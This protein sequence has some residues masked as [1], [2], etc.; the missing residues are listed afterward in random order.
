MRAALSAIAW[1]ALAVA[2]VALGADLYWCWS[3]GAWTFQPLGF[4]LNLTAADWLA[5][6]RDW[7]ASGSDVGVRLLNTLLALPVWVPAFAIGAPLGFATRE[8]A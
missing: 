8:R 5:Y 3:A 2:F 1:I 6:A 4:Y 7:A